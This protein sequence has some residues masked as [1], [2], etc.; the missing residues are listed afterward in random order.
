MNTKIKVAAAGFIGI[1]TVI[2]FW[3]L[4]VMP[5]Q[6]GAY[7]RDCIRK[8]MATEN[9]QLDWAEFGLDICSTGVKYPRFFLDLDE[10]RW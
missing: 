2:A 3:R 8:A 4:I 10:N 9:L 1:V 5:Y 7:F 6:Q